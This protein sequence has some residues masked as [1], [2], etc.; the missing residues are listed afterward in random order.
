MLRTYIL[1][2]VLLKIAIK[3]AAESD[4]VSHSSYCE[5]MAKKRTYCEI[6][7]LYKKSNIEHRDAWSN[8]LPYPL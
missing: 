5:V 8:V 1:R 2:V 7:N 4:F 3:A 6:E